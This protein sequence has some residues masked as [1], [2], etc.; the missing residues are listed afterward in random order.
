MQQTSAAADYSHAGVQDRAKR[1]DL[2]IAGL[3]AQWIFAVVI[4]IYWVLYFLLV[5]SDPRVLN[6]D[7]LNLVLSFL[8]I[9]VP[10]LLF[11]HILI[12]FWH[13]IRYVRPK[14]PTIWLIKDCW[15][16]FSDPRRLALGLPM[17]LFLNFFIDIFTDIKKN[18]PNLAPFAWDATFAE[19]DRLVHFGKHPWEWLQPL[20]GYWPVTYAINF[21]YNFW[22]LVMWMLWMHFAF[23]TQTSVLRTRFFLSFFLTWSVGGSFLAVIFSSAGP[24][25]YSLIGLSPDPFAGLMAYLR[26]VNAILPLMAI[27]I[28]DALWLS[29]VDKLMIGGITAMPSMHNAASLL[30]ALAGWQIGRRVGLILTIHCAL[31]FIG[32]IHLGWHYAIDAYAGWAVALPAWFLCKPVAQWWEGQP[33]SVR[34]GRLL[35]TPPAARQL[36]SS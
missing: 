21:S 14:H 34:L 28:Q 8:L 10:I 9:S 25:Y 4:G 20:L 24:C 16:F 23:A 33:A 7:V 19:W 6:T 3:S 5:R 1:K 26:E 17:V 13:M 15:A 32:S 36:R 35:Q 12:R 11:S 29:Y 2:L 18:I 30:F 22:F 31:V 27:K